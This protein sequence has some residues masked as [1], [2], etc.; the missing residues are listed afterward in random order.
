LPKLGGKVALLFILF[1]TYAS[2]LC[3]SNQKGEKGGKKC[4]VV[5]IT[6]KNLS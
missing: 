3:V 6:L 1:C 2:P 4:A 5:A